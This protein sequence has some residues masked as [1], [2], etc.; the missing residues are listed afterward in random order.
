MSQVAARLRFLL[1][2]NLLW[3]AEEGNLKET[4]RSLGGPW[5]SILN[6]ARENDS[7]YVSQPIFCNLIAAFH[8]SQIMCIYTL[9]N[10][11]KFKETWLIP[12]MLMSTNIC[13]LLRAKFVFIRQHRSSQRLHN[14]QRGI[15]HVAPPQPKFCDLS[16]QT[17][18]RLLRRP[19]C[20]GHSHHSSEM[21]QYKQENLRHY[22]AGSGGQ[23]ALPCLS[24]FCASENAILKTWS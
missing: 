17:Q 22:W 6:S 2:T 13:C 10:K 24:Y 11:T 12:I 23:G 15:F 18:S 20:E 3:G 21:P 14:L 1:G 19:V 4:S 9:N 7:K 8:T 16:P 5:D